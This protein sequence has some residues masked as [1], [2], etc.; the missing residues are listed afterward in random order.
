VFQSKTKVKLSESSLITNYGLSITKL[1]EISAH[2]HD[3][4]FLVGEYM[5]LNLY[6]LDNY[7][8]I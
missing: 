5:H 8:I 7:H 6:C 3:Y 1:S 2:S 4:E